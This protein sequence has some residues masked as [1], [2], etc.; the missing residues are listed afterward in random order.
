MGFDLWEA[1]NLWGQRQRELRYQDALSYRARKEG[2]KTPMSQDCTR[3]VPGQQQQKERPKE[4]CKQIVVD[5]GELSHNKKGTKK[6]MDFAE[7]QK[8]NGLES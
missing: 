4:P 3:D 2:A 5:N 1:M 6:W 8:L 7:Y